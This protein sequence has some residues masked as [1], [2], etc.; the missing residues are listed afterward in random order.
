MFNRA[1]YP[2]TLGSSLQSLQQVLGFIDKTPC[3][4]YTTDKHRPFLVSQRSSS[5]E[6]ISKPLKLLGSARRVKVMCPQ[7][8]QPQRTLYFAFGED[9]EVGGLQGAA[10]IADGLRR[11][12]VKLEFIMDEGGT[13]LRDG[14]KGITD[15]PVAV[16]ATAEKVMLWNEL[17]SFYAAA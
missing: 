2:L 13:V 11:Q 14:L 4:Q 7:R 17:D 8:Y 1:W 3:L 12:G 16:V 5:L 6:F 9:E 10:K 15:I